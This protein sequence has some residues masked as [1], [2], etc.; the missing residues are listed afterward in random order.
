M[1]AQKS[2]VLRVQIKILR[3]LTKITTRGEM[4]NTIYLVN[5]SFFSQCSTLGTTSGI[6]YVSIDKNLL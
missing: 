1:S 3:Y 5:T 4:N 2:I 6:D